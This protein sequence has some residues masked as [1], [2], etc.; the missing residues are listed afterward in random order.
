M[1][2]MKW[3]YYFNLVSNLYAKSAA[4]TT[5]LTQTFFKIIE[6]WQTCMTFQP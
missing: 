1:N 2:F 5:I 3:K 6:I 4:Q